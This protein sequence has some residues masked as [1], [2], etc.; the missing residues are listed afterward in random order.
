MAAQTIPQA[1]A[2]GNLVSADLEKKI[3]SATRKAEDMKRAMN[4]GAA[5]AR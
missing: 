4:G 5:E 2:A 3:E 1:V